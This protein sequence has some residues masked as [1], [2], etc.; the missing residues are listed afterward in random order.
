MGH[1]DRRFDVPVDRPGQNASEAGIL[2]LIAVAIAPSHQNSAAF[3]RTR[4]AA[5]GSA[6]DD[7]DTA[8]VA[9]AFVAA[10][11]CHCAAA[12]TDDG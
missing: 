7:G 12:E 3:G 10:A 8:A 9:A 6:E 5:I 11:G 2:R 4:V 1:V